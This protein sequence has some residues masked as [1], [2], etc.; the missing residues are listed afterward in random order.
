MS[1]N[2]AAA[3]W[4]YAHQDDERDG[5]SVTRL[6]ARIQDEFALV[7]GE[8]LKIFLD[9]TD[10]SWGDEWRRRI[11]MALA[12]TTF[13]I[14]VVTPS[15]L[16]SVECRR[17]LLAFIGQ[18]Q[19]LGVTD[20]LMPILYVDVPELTEQ[21][22]DEVC[23][24]IAK[25]QCVD[26]RDIRLSAHD[27][28]EYRRGVNSLALR[29]AEVASRHEQVSSE[30]AG[31]ED[32]DEDGLLDLLA[33]AE[34]KLELWREAIDASDTIWD[35]IRIIERSAADKVARTGGTRGGVN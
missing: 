27:S 9:R 23:A 19:S 14:P 1:F 6:A 25:A 16:K 29:L 15:Y 21:S 3:F 30:Q 2:Q 22:T 32:I 31:L 13:F 7:T 11:S 5:H 33:I 8:T 10:I 35:Q 4:S 20:L 12:E 17:E 18:A 34:R 26:W 28:A 24:S